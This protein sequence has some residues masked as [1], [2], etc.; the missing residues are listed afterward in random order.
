MAEPR[1]FEDDD[2]VQDLEPEPPAEYVPSE[3][4]PEP[5]VR[6][7]PQDI[8]A[9]VCVLGACILEPACYQ[10]ASQY[11]QAS[12]FFR[13]AHQIIWQTIV[14]MN[15]S[16]T[17]IDLV[18]LRDELRRRGKLDEVGGIEYI[19]IMLE[20][21]P[22]VDNSAYY[23]RIVRDK[24]ML[25]SAIRIGLSIQTE[26]WSC[27]KMADELIADALVQLDE[28]MRRSSGLGWQRMNA[29]EA[30]TAAIQA[31]KNPSRKPIVRFGYSELDRLVGGLRGGDY[32]VLAGVTS[33][34]KT[35]AALNFVR[36]I[37]QE[38]KA[39]YFLSAE[40]RP[41]QLMHRVLAMTSGIPLWKIRSGKA[42]APLTDLPALQEV[43][44]DI[45]RWKLHIDCVSRTPRQISASV[46]TFMH[47]I[48]GPVDLVVIDYLQKLRMGGRYMKRY[49]MFS[50]I[51]SAL[52]QLA[53]V[54]LNIPI[55]VLSQFGRDVGREDRLPTRY[56]L[57]ESGEIEN[58]A[59]LILLLHCPPTTRRENGKALDEIWVKIDKQRQG[60]VNSWPCEDNQGAIVLGRDCSTLNLHTLHVYD[61]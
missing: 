53:L 29:R 4:G 56:D 3:T 23:G 28:T 59:D 39:V 1:P 33:A 21:V 47:E 5:P 20:G 12:D 38:D 48:Q 43:S 16:G 13:P 36:N 37:C 7:P 14:E 35:T 40:M 19:Q 15:E 42:D 26:A 27:S 2:F 24:A 6:V 34:G 51:S 30:V 61:P 9:E 54:E 52:K 49:E 8:E 18:T 50:E 60:L 55:L 22:T 46:K 17:P 57:K 41:D 45:S 31:M 25:R 58:D 32:A 11:V 44:D 10:T